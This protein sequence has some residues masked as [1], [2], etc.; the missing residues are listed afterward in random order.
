MPIST[1]S[2]TNISEVGG[3]SAVRMLRCKSVIANAEMPLNVK[4]RIFHIA[5][6]LQLG[7]KKFYIT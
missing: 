6:K 3:I 4:S 7:R 5:H 1:K 2:I